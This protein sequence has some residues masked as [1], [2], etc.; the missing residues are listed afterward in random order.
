[1]ITFIDGLDWWS[2]YISMAYLENNYNRTDFE[3]TD[4]Q[5]VSN[6]FVIKKDHVEETEY[7]RETNS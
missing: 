5:H 4:D 6:N 7:T 2:W 1:M 3:E